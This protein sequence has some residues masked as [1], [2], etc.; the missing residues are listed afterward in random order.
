MRANR[1]IRPAQLNPARRQ[2]TWLG[3]LRDGAV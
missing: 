1:A 2:S 3:Q